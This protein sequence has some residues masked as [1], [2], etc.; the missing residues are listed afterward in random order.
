MLLSEAIDAL[1]IATRVNGR[2]PRTAEG[3]REKLRQLLL[4]LGDVPVESITV[5]DLRRFVA[6]LM[7]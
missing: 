1:C 5:D 4:F 2:S 6:W 7:D 3:Y